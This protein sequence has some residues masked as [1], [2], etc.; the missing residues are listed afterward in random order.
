MKGRI[1]A[2]LERRHAEGIG[3]YELISRL[4]YRRAG[5]EKEA[6][7]T[8]AIAEVE[9]EEP[10]GGVVALIHQLRELF[11][12]AV[13]KGMLRRVREGRKLP[14]NAIKLMTGAEFAFEDEALLDIALSEDQYD[15][16]AEAAAFALGSHA[17]GRLIDRMTELREEVRAS[18]GRDKEAAFERHRT[19]ERRME[20]AKTAHVLAAIK[21]RSMRAN[22]QALS[23]FANVIHRQGDGTHRHGQTFDDDAEA[24]IAGFVH[25]WGNRLLEAPEATREQLASVA[26][27]AMHAPS[28]DLLPVLE[29]LLNEELRRLQTFGEEARALK[30]RNHPATNEWR[31]RWSGCY[32][33]T[34]LAIR[35]PQT[36]TLM[37]KYLLD[38]EFGKPAACVLAEQWRAAHEPR[39]DRCWSNRPYFS[40]VTQ[41]RDVWRIHPGASS[42]EADVIFGAV[43]QLIGVDA[44][45]DA[46]KRAVALGTVAAAL[47]HGERSDILSTLIGMADVG[48]RLALLTNL[49]LSG[50]TIDVE[51]VKTG[52]ADVLE[53]A[54][55][56]P[57]IITEHGELRTWLSLL[58]F[59]NRPSEVIETMLGLPEEHRRP[60]GLEPMIEALT[61]APG[62]EAEAV[63]FRMAE[64]DPRLYAQQAWRNA[65]CER[66][67]QSSAMHFV[68]LIREGRLNC[69][70]DRDQRGMRRRVACLMDEHTDVRVQVYRIL[71][72]AETSAGMRILADAVAEKPDMDGLMLLI[73]LD[74]RHDQSFASCYTV[75][76][77]VMERIASESWG[78][79]EVM[80]VPAAAL[81]RK[82]LEMT[83]D[84]GPSDIAARYLRKIHEARER[85]GAPESEPRHPDIA[86]G[87]PWPI[88]DQQPGRNHG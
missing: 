87:K 77:V 51:L 70:D 73:Q 17:V 21:S 53:A 8:T 47:P 41:K 29:R 45:Q 57:W 34:F 14:V 46:R 15:H 81:R 10:N 60:D 85:I 18:D 66:G 28:P 59:T 76:Q 23:D 30:Y 1:T 84:G 2:A 56:Q 11:P 83:T 6:E 50:K 64:I 3:P 58:P 5:E 9:I 49:V 86:S 19:I 78:A 69:N 54:R 7:V 79:Y 24:E 52:I 44:T 65:V 62:D 25:D 12:S 13:G 31:T 39:D 4:R 75:E 26:V 88:I 38:E 72:D 68:D 40:R 27:L 35:S 48:S 20:F 63:L 61:H 71:G 43:E 33:R 74:M 80:P 36:A 32:Q 22:C 82:L 37:E 55:T 42:A 67:T 16:R